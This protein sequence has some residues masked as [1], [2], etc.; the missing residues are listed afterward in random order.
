MKK[1]YIVAFLSILLSAC[2]AYSDSVHVH[3]PLPDMSKYDGFITVMYDVDSEGRIISARITNA[4]PEE[5]IGQ[6]DVLKQVRKWKFEKGKPAKD[7][8][9]TI[10]FKKSGNAEYHR[11][12]Q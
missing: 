7:E 3:N 1:A 10:L 9:L 11:I 5:I 2:S 6:V 8:T 12:N 4:V